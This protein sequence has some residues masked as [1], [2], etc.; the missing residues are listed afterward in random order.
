MR[1][2]FG[3]ATPQAL[4]AVILLPACADSPLPG[5]LL[6]TYKVQAQTQSNACGLAA[7]N[8]WMF[9][10]QVSEEGQTFYWSW[11][12]GTPPLSAFMTS[13]TAVSLL[14]SQQANVDSTADGGQGPCVMER[15]DTVTVALGSGSPPP[16][17]SGTI[18]YAFSVADGSTCTDQLAVSGGQYTALPCTITYTMTATRQ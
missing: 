8:P 12:D 9:D 14:A 11:L 13:S 2:F 1:R 7:P 18:G 3:L 15:D 4:L 17:F 6:G 10:V 5:H 16:T